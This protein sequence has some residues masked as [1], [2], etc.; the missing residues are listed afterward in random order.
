VEQLAVRK[1]GLWLKLEKL[2]KNG[3]TVGL[4]GSNSP[5]N[6]ASRPVEILK[7]DEVDK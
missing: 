1:R 3:V 4:I 6:L 2:F 7:M 5:S